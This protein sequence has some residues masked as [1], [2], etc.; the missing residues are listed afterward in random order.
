MEQLFDL[1]I[2][3]GVEEDQVREVLEVLVKG[4][5][6]D[7]RSLIRL[8]QG[9]RSDKLLRTFLK[10]DQNRSLRQLPSRSRIPNL[11]RRRCSK[12]RLPLTQMKRRRREKSKRKRSRRRTEE[13]RAVRRRALQSEV[14]VLVLMMMS[15]RDSEN[16]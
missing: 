10:I 1:S 12:Y 4:R 6:F 3:A 14:I 5:F 11:R 8:R 13:V 7:V 15:S 16:S 9:R 2:K